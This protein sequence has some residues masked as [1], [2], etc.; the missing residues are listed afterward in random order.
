MGL[1]VRQVGQGILVLWRDEFIDE[2]MVLET[3]GPELGNAI[4]IGRV[5]V[6]FGL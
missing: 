4:Q 2:R 6:L 5:D 3:G 1:D